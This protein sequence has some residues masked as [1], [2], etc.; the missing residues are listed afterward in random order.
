MTNIKQSQTT[1]AAELPYLKHT[2]IIELTIDVLSRKINITVPH[3]DVLIDEETLVFVNDVPAKKMP[4]VI[5][6]Y[7]LKLAWG[8]NQYIGKVICIKSRTDAPCDPAEV[9]QILSTLGVAKALYVSSLAAEAEMT[10][11]PVRFLSGLEL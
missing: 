7:C 4:I 2:Q 5:G 8:E 10:Q 11:V 9:N 3:D 6:N 1:V